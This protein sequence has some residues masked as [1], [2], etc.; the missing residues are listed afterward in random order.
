MINVGIEKEDIDRLMKQ[1]EDLS[2]KNMKTAIRRASKRVADSMKSEISSKVTRRYLIKAADVKSAFTLKKVE[3]GQ[4]MYYLKYTGSP[5]LLMKFRVTPKNPVKYTHRTTKKGKKNTR[6]TPKT[7]KAR[8]LKSNKLKGV[9]NM[10]IAKN[11]A[12]IRPGKVS[13]SENKKPKNWLAFGP[14]VPQMVGSKEILDEIIESGREFFNNRL[15]HE[16][17]YIL[18]EK[19]TG[20]RGN[21][22]TKSRTITIPT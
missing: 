20:N 14:S 6:R 21:I 19:S 8:V 4:P 3:G 16:I 1:F 18:A 12:L 5:I 17:E 22:D 7:Y 10:F 2:E 13:R 15:N 11:Q 9:K